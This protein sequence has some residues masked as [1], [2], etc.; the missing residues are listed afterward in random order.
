MR[1]RSKYR[2]HRFQERQVSGLSEIRLLRGGYKRDSD[3]GTERSR[4]GTSRFFCGVSIEAAYGS[5]WVL[6][7]ASGL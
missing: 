6:S 7:H 3:R 4:R 5:P 2:A 1:N